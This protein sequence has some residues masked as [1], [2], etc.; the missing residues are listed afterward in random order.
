M[1]QS[2]AVVRDVARQVSTINHRTEGRW[3]DEKAYDGNMW[4]DWKEK[5]Q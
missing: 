2:P 3:H 4:F 1:S 5:A